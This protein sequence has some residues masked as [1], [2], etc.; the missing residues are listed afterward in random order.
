MHPETHRSP[1]REPWP[2]IV[3]GML[4][5]MIGISTTFFVIAVS[6]PDPEVSRPAAE[7]SLR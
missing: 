2:W 3:G 4:A 6:H 1:Q 5:L 7:G